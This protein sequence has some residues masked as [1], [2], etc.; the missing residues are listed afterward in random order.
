V[1]A[2]GADGPDGQFAGRVAALAAAEPA[3]DAVARLWRDPSAL[4][5]GADR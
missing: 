2:G 4:L 1:R 5:P 3:R